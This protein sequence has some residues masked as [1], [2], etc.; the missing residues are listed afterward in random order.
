MAKK[1][2]LPVISRVTIKGLDF[3]RLTY[4]QEG[5]R[6]RSHFRREEDA[7][8]KQS[9]ISAEIKK[10]GVNWVDLPVLLRAQALEARKILEGTGLTIADAARQAVAGM[11][12]REK[13]VGDAAAE[14]MRSRDSRGEKYRHQLRRQMDSFVQ[15][16]AGRTMASIT[17][18]DIDSFLDGIRGRWTASTRNSYR[19]ALAMLF[20]RGVALD[21][22]RKNPC[23]ITARETSRDVAISALT[24]EEARNILAASDSEL[25]PAVALCLF[26]GLRWSEVYKLRWEDIRIAGNDSQITIG[27]RVAK[28]PSRRVVEV[29]ANAIAFLKTNV[30]GGILE[31]ST[32]SR[33]RWE[34]A[35]VKAGYGPFSF[36]SPEVRKAQEGRVLK[37]WPDNVLR[38]TAISA[39]LAITKDLPAVAYWA[40]NSAATIQQHYNGL[41]PATE[42][43]E[44]FKIKAGSI[45]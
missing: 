24:A 45:G 7:T 19:T 43:R 39:R 21:Y 30:T 9:V 40:G 2:G 34:L 36:T 3:Y 26:C 1:Q 11:A 13:S 17:T 29:P 5:K 35:R 41:M 31:P 25:R 32:K 44:F 37:P 10:H 16:F 22:C 12:T 15:H 27:V 6:F 4:W 33:R 38:H 8:A 23:A 28:K 42:A 14:F 18:G 20:R